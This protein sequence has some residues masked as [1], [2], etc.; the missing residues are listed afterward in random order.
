MR[1]KA[2][3]ALKGLRRS[4]VKC[5]YNELDGQKLDLVFMLNYMNVT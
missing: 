2:S 4:D 5:S 3:P 1:L